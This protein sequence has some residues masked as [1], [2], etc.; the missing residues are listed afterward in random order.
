[1][2][3]VHIL[4]FLCKGNK[5]PVKLRRFFVFFCIFAQKN[6][7][8]AKKWSKLMNIARNCKVE[9]STMPWVNFTSVVL[10]L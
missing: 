7:D 6:L 3:F 1:M 10:G 4:V 9:S 8:R 2:H 5:K